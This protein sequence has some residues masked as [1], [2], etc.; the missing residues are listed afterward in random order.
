[1]KRQI[2]QAENPTPA[3][4]ISM[5]GTGVNN[6]ILLD[7]LTSEVALDEPGIGRDHR[8]IPID[9]IC[10]DSELHFGIAGCSR[11]YEDEG[12]K[13]HERDAIPTTS[14]LRWAVTELERFDL[15]ISDVGGYEGKDGD[16]VDEDEMEEASQV[17]MDQHRM[18]RTQ[19]IV[20]KSV[21]I[22]QYISDL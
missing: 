14:W 15:G 21:K 16:D 10:T 20:P 11:D 12:D 22:G 9:I 18:W 8:I 4:V 19:G 2:Q 13:S 1:V 7:Y 6:A 17:M 5:E 3:M